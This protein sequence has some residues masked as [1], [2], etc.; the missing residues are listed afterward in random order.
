[1]TELFVAINAK[2]P[3]TNLAVRLL[4]AEVKKTGLSCGYIEH[5]INSDAKKVVQD[6][7]RYAPKVISFSC[8]IWNI[9]YIFSLAKAIKAKTPEI[10]VLLGGPEVSFDAEHILERHA[11]IDFIIRGE[12][13][14]AHVDFAYHLLGKKKLADCASLTYRWDNE[15]R[16]TPIQIN[17]AFET[18]PFPYPDLSGLK[19]RVIYY[20][21]SRGCP[22]AC[23][24]CLSSEY[25]AYREKPL[26][27][28]QRDLQQFIDADVKIVKFVDRT[29]NTKKSRAV[30]L[31]EFIKQNNKNT[32][33]HLEL[34]PTLLDD[35]LIDCLS[36]APVG[37]FQLEIGIQS[38]HPKT[39]TA[40]NRKEDFAAFAP[41]LK[42][43]V[44]LKNMHLHVDLIA[45][46]PYEGLTEF[47]QSFDD[48]F[49]LGADNLQ[50]G[51]LKLLKGA[52]LREQAAALDIQYTQEAPYE[53]TQTRWL[54]SADLA[55][56]ES[57]EYL[58]KRIYN[59]GL[60]KYTTFMLS[61]L[62]G[63]AFSLFLDIHQT[64]QKKKVSLQN[65]SEPQL[66]AFLWEYCET[67]DPM[68]REM[69][70]F[71]AM[72]KRKRPRLPETMLGEKQRTF[73]KQYFKDSDIPEHLQRS[74]YPVQFSFDVLKF[75]QT[76]ECVKT[77]TTLI[78]DYSNFDQGVAIYGG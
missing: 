40:I 33:F 12:G 16:S 52:P 18:A 13:E 73:R 32:C 65:F 30:A 59:S 55:L 34:A 38:T 51:F 9:T 36:T 70:L 3:H 66:L 72:N 60:F 4:D 23:A 27:L 57:I 5:T 74:L 61:S 31:I 63:S 35:A 43:L 39:L 76:F 58:L 26:D 37:T 53:V 1:M 28:V 21:A 41:K 42:R 11:Y 14:K 69:L 78:F 62:T 7:L 10:K 46:L 77:C 8:Y 17:R 15:I 20:E 25:G 64:L 6:I 29:F 68:V 50:L 47:R 44:A 54:S 22:F 75:T 71:E 49:S 19:N 56:L 45:G 24:F 67:A 2:Y 48:V